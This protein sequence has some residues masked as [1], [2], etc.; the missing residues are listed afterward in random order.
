MLD[1]EHARRRVQEAAQALQGRLGGFQP[2]VA[3]ILGSG[4]GGFVSELS[5]SIEIPY[6]QLPHFPVST[7]AGHAGKWVA[8]TVEGRSVLCM[9]GRFHYYEGYSMQEVT[10]PIRVMK[11]LNIGTLIVTNAAGGIRASFQPGDLM[12]IEDHINW[13]FDNPLRGPNVDEWGPRFPDMSHA[14]D[15]DLIACAEK[16]AADFGITLHRGV[17][18]AVPGPS[19]ETPAE[20]RAFAKLGADAVGMSTVPEVIVA[21]HQG[22]NVLGISCISNMASGILPEPLSHEDVVRTSQQVQGRL[23]RLVKGVLKELGR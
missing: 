22:M 4:L 17:Y 13:M 23:T 20:I 16:V 10:F 19:Y 2:E 8:G 6:D 1:A 21:N 11:E 14:Y 18:I 9:Q 15:P 12:L 3:V 5:D 7:V